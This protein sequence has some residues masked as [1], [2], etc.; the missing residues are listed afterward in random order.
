MRIIPALDMI[1]GKCVRLEQGD[2]DRKKEYELSPVDYAKF[3][4]DQG[5]KYLHLVDLDG[6]RKGAP[7]HLNILEEICGATSL[8]VDFGG[9]VKNTE[10]V[11][12]VFDCGAQQVTAGSLAVKNPV[13]VC[14][15]LSLFGA[16]KVILGADVKDE[17]IYINGWKTSTEIPLFTFLENFRKS[18]IQY[19]VCTD[20]SKDGLLQGSSVG[21]YKK[22]REKFPELKLIASGGIH[23]LEDLEKLKAEGMEGAIVGKALLENKVDL[24]KMRAYVD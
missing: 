14:E 10:T 12:Q 15:W 16:E 23:T 9:G 6:A 3:L 19:V 2:F 21:L 8:K 18:G 20:I 13:E 4:E 1:G 11:K 17:I 5:F 7:V 22:I 24:S